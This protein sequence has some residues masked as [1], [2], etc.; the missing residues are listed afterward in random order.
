MKSKLLITS[1]AILL[2]VLSDC[3]KTEEPDDVKV[4]D[5]YYV[6]YEV[7]INKNIG[8][9]TNHIT[10][11]T[12]NGDMSFQTTGNKSF[13]ETFGPVKKN[14]KARIQVY[15]EEMRTATVTV[16][17]YVSKGK[18]AFVLKKINSATDPLQANPVVAEYT[19]DF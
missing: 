12:E 2:V 7:E 15:V 14:F 17:I 1:V 3:K 16:R 8:T 13:S 11:K 5:R 18:E 9:N 4:E 19:I 6:K 10:V